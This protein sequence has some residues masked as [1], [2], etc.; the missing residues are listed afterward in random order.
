MPYLPAA[1]AGPA[2]FAAL[3]PSAAWTG[4]PAAETVS[5]PSSVPASGGSRSKAGHPAWT[6][7]HDILSGAGRTGRIARRGLP[8]GE[9]RPCPGRIIRTGNIPQDTAGTAA[10]ALSAHDDG[11][12]FDY[13]SLSPAQ[14]FGGFLPGRLEDSA[15]GGP[16]NLEAPRGGLD[17]PA[18]VIDQPK[19]FVFIEPDNHLFEDPHRHPLGFEKD[20]RGGKLDKALF[21][22]SRHSDSFMRIFS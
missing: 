20:R 13:N 18:F 9:L 11:A 10:E 2:P 21:G 3:P 16:G 1:P 22:E 14:R 12:A 19:H 17:I 4:S 5:V 7:L 6:K 15:G 8:G